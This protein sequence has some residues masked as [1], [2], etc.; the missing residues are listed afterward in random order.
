MIARSLKKL[1]LSESGLTRAAVRLMARSGPI[2]MLMVVRDEVDIIAQN[3]SFHLHFGI[4]NFVI[5][6][7]GSKD[8][9]REIL[10]DFERRL[11]RSMM[12]VDDAEPAH[13]QSARVNRMIQIAKRKFQ[14][15]WIISSDADE[16]WY[17]ASGRYDSEIDGR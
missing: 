5:T 7:N 8:G 6:D 2:T 17:P 10:A 1:L 3:I 4:E 11:G 16:F 14:P 15:R 12:I 13:H 9:T